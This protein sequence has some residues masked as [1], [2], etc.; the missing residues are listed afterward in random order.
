MTTAATPAGGIRS[1][2]GR[3]VD[4]SAYGYALVLT[5]GLSFVLAIPTLDQ[6]WFPWDEGTLGQSAQRVLHG[7]LPHRDFV[8]AYTGGLAFYDAGVF[9]L[10]GTDLLWLR[11]AMLPL[12]AA[13]VVAAFYIAARF[14][15]PVYAGLLT[16]IC[17]L[18]SVPNYPAAMPSW[19]NLFLATVGVAS[20]V[21]FCDR[22]E[23]RWLWVAGLAG[24]VSI[25]V[26]VVGVYFVIGV[27]LFLLFRRRL[28]SAPGADGRRGFD[29]V[30]TIAF[31]LATLAFVVGIVAG[32]ASPAVFVAF[33]VPVAAV[34][35][36]VVLVE[37]L[38]GDEPVVLARAARIDLVHFLAA[39]AVPLAIFAAPYVVTGSLGDLIGDLATA[40]QK[41]LE[42]ASFAPLPV[43]WIVYA[44][45]LVAAALVP[46][47]R[48]RARALAVAGIGALALLGATL[49]TMASATRL[50]VNP[51]R[52]LVPVVA[53]AGSAVVA[54][55]ALHRRRS[56]GRAEPATVLVFAAV[57]VSLVQFPFAAPIYFFYAFP[58]VALA[59][60]AL[61]SELELARE[62]L[63]AV[64]GVAYLIV[65]LFHLQQSGST[66]AQ[67]MI[68]S[69][70]GL[71][72]LDRHRARI[73]V[74]SSD[75]ATYRR[76]TQLLHAHA[77]SGVT[78]AG[79]D[80]PEIYYLAGLANPTP[81]LFDFLSSE[82]ARDRGV[83]D[84]IARDPINAIVV[85][86]R[87]PFSHPYDPALLQRLERTFPHHQLVDH[88]DVRWRA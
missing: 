45:P 61:L 30:L 8:D 67:A 11:V 87:P 40:S 23:R 10:F 54:L 28:R 32:L 88:F 39:A 86:Q 79:P 2:L 53:I 82:R 52:E 43:H 64:V 27:I 19:Y 47:L 75:A 4:L 50:F 59:A 78:I 9:W 69:H 15:P 68:G 74:S 63:V 34:V 3:T 48:G 17:V 18:W 29:S 16:L 73:Y 21:R 33:V 62:P 35:G 65:G 31:A 81:E 26:K 36:A 83:L 71:T 58:L 42:F 51:A 20:V 38:A 14:V 60:V 55:T 41:R 25:A 57:L 12:F 46:L 80:S 37:L 85:N 7:E 22:G 49:P 1:R 66:L 72:V 77:R 5:L 13:F 70:P 6:R 24:G 56:R 76:V 84:A 44:M